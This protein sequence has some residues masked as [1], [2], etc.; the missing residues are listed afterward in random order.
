M[1]K[2]KEKEKDDVGGVMFRTAA[3][4]SSEI[5]FS[6]SLFRHLIE[7]VLWG[8]FLRMYLLEFA[9]GKEAKAFFSFLFFPFFFIFNFKDTTL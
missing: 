3:S 4:S 5:L 9:L 8:F 1:E 7:V 2:E 6:I